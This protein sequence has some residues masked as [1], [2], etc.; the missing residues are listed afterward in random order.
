MVG[1]GRFPK[2]LGLLFLPEVLNYTVAEEAT[3]RNQQG[4]AFSEKS[5]LS[6]PSLP[7]V[8]SP[9]A[10]HGTPAVGPAEPHAEVTVTG[11]L[12]P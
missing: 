11:V 5:M 2:A 3:R 6:F 7:V 9:A 1:S 10:Q 4:L 8:F 12:S